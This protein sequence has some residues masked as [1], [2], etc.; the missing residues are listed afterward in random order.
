[1][2]IIFNSYVPL[3]IHTSTAFCL[4]SIIINTRPGLMDPDVSEASRNDD[5]GGG[6]APVLQHFTKNRLDRQQHWR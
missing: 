3:R 6:G 5:G 2:I 4:Q 1:M